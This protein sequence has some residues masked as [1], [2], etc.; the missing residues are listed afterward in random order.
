MTPK[1]QPRVLE[2][3]LD[4]SQ[5]GCQEVAT[6]EMG[7]HEPWVDPCPVGGRRG[8]RVDHLISPKFH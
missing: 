8:A 4:G 3:D 5:K 1:A 2:E 7:I 6:E